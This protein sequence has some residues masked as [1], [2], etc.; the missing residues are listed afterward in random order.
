MVQNE[1]HEDDEQS[2]NKVVEKELNKK[3]EEK[4]N[5]RYAADDFWYIPTHLC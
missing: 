4:E 2:L 3:R 1:E 5:I